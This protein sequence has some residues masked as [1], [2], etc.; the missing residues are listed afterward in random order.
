[1]SMPTK[2][3]NRASSQFRRNNQTIFGV[4]LAGLGFFPLSMSEKRHCGRET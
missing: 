2:R 3:S 1:L 4:F